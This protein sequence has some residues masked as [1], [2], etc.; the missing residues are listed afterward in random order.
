MGDF[1]INFLTANLG[2]GLAVLAVWGLR[3]PVRAMFGAQLA[4]ALWLLVPLIAAATCLPPRTIEVIRNV[5]QPAAQSV[6][7]PNKSTPASADER[8]LDA[9]LG[10]KPSSVTTARPTPRISPPAPR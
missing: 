10:A 7:A 6:A 2:A 9:T 4:Y 3:R 8:R 1:A 5:A